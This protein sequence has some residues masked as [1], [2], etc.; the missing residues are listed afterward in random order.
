MTNDTP[1]TPL[2]AD[3]Q[4]QAI[5]SL[6]GYD[7]QIWRSVE[8]WMQLDNGQLLYL[9]GAEDFD[10]VDESGDASTFQ[11]KNSGKPITLGSPDVRK[12]IE[13]FWSHV[14]RNAGRLIRMRFVT[15]GD[16]GSEKGDPFQG[17]KGIDVWR[18]A[19][20]GNDEAAVR[21]ASHLKSTLNAQ[22]LVDFL[23]SADAVDLRSRLF[24]RVDWATNEPS[25]EA[26]QLAVE[27][28]A[29]D[30]GDERDI[31]SNESLKAVAGLL[32]HCRATIHHRDPNQRCLSRA[33]LLRVF[34]AKTSVMVPLTRGLTSFLERALVA[35]HTSATGRFNAVSF[36]SAT[37]GIEPELPKFCLPRKTL[38]D[39]I[40][41]KGHPALIV[42]SEG[43]GKTTIASLVA[44]A[45]GG[46]VCWVDLS[47]LDP[48]ALLSAFDHL[49]LAIRALPTNAVVVVDDFPITPTINQAVWTRFSAVVSQS[50]RRQQFLILTAKGVHPEAIDPRLRT[51]DVHIH[52]VPDLSNEETTEF[53]SVLGCPDEQCSSFAAA[54]L[55]RS[56][57]G[58]PKLVHLLGLELQNSEW[59][60]PPD[61]LMSKPPTSIEE[62]RAFARR[63]AA[64]ALPE[65]DLDLLYSLSL[66]LCALDRQ[67]V[68]FI[69]EKFVGL[70]S[71]G[72]ALDH[73]LGQWVET[74]APS[75]YRITA[76]LF[77]QAE[78][79]WSTSKVAQA[80]GCIFD[81]LMSRRSIS[82]DKAS[83]LFM[84]AWESKDNARLSAILVSLADEKRTLRVRGAELLAPIV[85]VARGTNA[86][87]SSFS[88]GTIALLRLTQFRIAKQQVK[89]AL[90]SLAAE[91]ETAIKGIEEAGQRDANQLMWAMSVAD[92]PDQSFGPATIVHALE[93]VNRLESVVADAP[94]SEG[95]TADLCPGGI[96]EDADLVATLFGFNFSRC[97]E[98]DQLREFVA[99]LELAVPE[100]RDRMLKAFTIP[101]FSRCHLFVQAPWRSESN[102]PEPRW[103]LAEETLLRML[104]LAEKWRAKPMGIAVARLLSILYEDHLSRDQ[105][106]LECLRRAAEI[107]GDSP[108]LTAQEGAV[109]FGRKDF[110]KAQNLWKESLWRPSSSRPDLE[111]DPYVLR[112]AGFASATLRDFESASDWFEIT[113]KS[114]TDNAL[115]AMAGGALFDAAYCA[116]KDG[117]RTRVVALLVSAL[118]ALERDYDPAAQFDL[119]AAKKLGGHV[120]RWIYEQLR[121]K[122][123]EEPIFEPQVGQC[124]NPHRDRALAETPKLPSEMAAAFV[125]EIASLLR[126]K[127]DGVEA[128]RAELSRSR[129]LAAGSLYWILRSRETIEN[130]ELEQLSTCLYRESEYM[131]QHL[132]Q[133]RQDGSLPNAILP[134]DGE[135]LDSDRATPVGIESVFS[136][137]LFI[138][139]L[140]GGSVDA[141]ANHWIADLSEFAHGSTLPSEARAA[142]H[143]IS[144]DESEASKIADDPNAMPFDRMS[145][146]FRLLMGNR[147][148]PETTALCQIRAINWLSILSSKS[149]LDGAFGPLA[150]A[151]ASMWRAH[152]QTAAL[153]R[154]PNLAIPM[155]Q[156]AIRDDE[157]APQQLAQL[158]RAA[159]FATSVVVPQRVLDLLDQAATLHR[160]RLPW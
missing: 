38:V 10:V 57:G 53:L 23:R 159:S 110:K 125:V 99:A 148:A 54:I 51:A 5:D 66:A 9:E 103:Q 4:R 114:A 133:R 147:R 40:I 14:E 142:L 82:I 100:A 123:E 25:T 31:D 136:L 33:D 92:A 91:W 117:K 126:V 27:R 70:R 130:G 86:D 80:H 127:S 39:E 8:A 146:V 131:W 58:H 46:H 78:L 108:V 154:S 76:L 41:R 74:Q 116:F 138:R 64:S 48:S 62:A 145:A 143:A 157:N 30:L 75:E 84:H 43:R 67:A 37:L 85:L 52:A 121:G 90:P 106:S 111:R 72:D 96:T 160:A 97:E 95:L 77:R 112:K 11:I 152:A 140:S 156:E 153:L 6:R 158:L 83:A 19:A 134:F 44:R 113:S 47:A 124:S 107:F 149:F 141:L 17:E 93:E 105:D 102:K 12:A 34:E 21:V 73:L 26:I 42:G 119:F 24:Q 29:I 28:A 120:L 61:E 59:R 63:K 50:A 98:L 122:L 22:N 88:A 155:L 109:Y 55:A 56:G 68:M 137:G 20:K 65:S 60:K 144:V 35:E 129:T 2:A 104:S 101:L 89:S 15:R 71:P 18:R 128:L 139:F 151:F 69:G 118:S 49:L 87:T 135:V 1:S 32:A 94:I 150:K 3:T 79:A 45:L 115:S 132:A 16:V 7:Y 36:S 13:N 81:A